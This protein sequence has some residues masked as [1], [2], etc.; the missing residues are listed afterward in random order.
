MAG[1]LSEYLADELLDHVFSAATFTPPAT[2]YIAL[3]TVAPTASGGGTEVTGGSYARVS[4][5]NNATNWPAASGQTKRNGTAIT[6]PAPSADWAPS[7]SPVVGV[8]VF[9]A[10]T[11]GNMLIYGPLSTPRVIINGDAAPVIAING[12]TFTL[13]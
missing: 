6:F 8:A 4:V 11:S 1:F 9:D 13:E 2:V 12:G 10:S 5:T 3:F 7:G